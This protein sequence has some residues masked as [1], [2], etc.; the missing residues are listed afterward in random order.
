M[1]QHFLL[2]TM[3]VA[4]DL[5][6]HTSLPHTF[7]SPRVS[8]VILDFLTVLWK[9]PFQVPRCREA[10]LKILPIFTAC[11]IFNKICR[12]GEGRYCRVHLFFASQGD[13]ILNSLAGIPDL[14]G[15]KRARSSLDIPWIGVWMKGSGLA[16][17]REGRCF[18]PSVWLL[19]RVTGGKLLLLFAPGL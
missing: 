8:F 17:G 19:L 1:L 6:K 3:L 14:C 10:Q 9:I 11:E 16:G 18:C 2:R 12:M 15:H 5:N 4:G 13:K 7:T